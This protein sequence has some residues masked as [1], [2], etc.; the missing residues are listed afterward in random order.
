MD[1]NNKKVDNKP[2]E[3]RRTNSLLR[4]DAYLSSVS[5]IADPNLVST[6]IMTLPSGKFG[7]KISA[8]VLEDKA[9]SNEGD[10]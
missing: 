4:M 8:E 6:E 10:S 1:E 7:N 9:I 2:R 5:E 3:R